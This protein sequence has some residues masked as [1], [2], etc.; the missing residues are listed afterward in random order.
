MKPWSMWKTSENYVLAWWVDAREYSQ[1][2]VHC[3]ACWFYRGIFLVNKIFSIFAFGRLCIFHYSEPVS[4][5]LSR[6]VTIPVFEQLEKFFGGEDS[7]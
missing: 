7:C 5:H 4:V 2:M 6:Y 3:L 1:R